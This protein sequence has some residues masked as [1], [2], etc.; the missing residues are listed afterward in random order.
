MKSVTLRAYAKVNLGLSVIG[1]RD[2]GLVLNDLLLNGR[3]PEE[4]A[5]LFD[6]HDLAW[7]TAAALPPSVKP[8]TRK[9][10]K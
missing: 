4:A 7:E 2:D 8:R 10:A 5:C 9:Y 6:A 3:L 1:R